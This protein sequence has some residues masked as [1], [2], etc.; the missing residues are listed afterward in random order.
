MHKRPLLLIFVGCCLL[1]GLSACGYTQPAGTTSIAT[2]TASAQNGGIPSALVWSPDGVRIATAYSSGYIEIW[3]ATT[4][5]NLLVYTEH[6]VSNTSLGLYVVA[7][8]PDGHYIVSGGF[9]GTA[10]VWEAATGKLIFTYTAQPRG[11]S[12]AC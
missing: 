8:S 12:L 2:H 5:K 10:Q 1:L 11:I 9:D 6:K 7:W 3:Q 4:G